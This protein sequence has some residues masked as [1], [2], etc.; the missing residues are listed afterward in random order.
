MK[1]YECPHCHHLQYELNT[2]NKCLLLMDDKG[3]ELFQNRQ[4][5]LAMKLNDINE[6]R[7]ISYNLKSDKNNPIV[8]YAYAY[9]IM[10][11]DQSYIND[12][13]ETKYYNDEI[14]S[15]MIGHI[16]DFPDNIIDQYLINVYGE[17]GMY[18]IKNNNIDIDIPDDL[19][20]EVKF[21]EKENKNDY[22]KSGIVYIIIG[23]VLFA[24]AML[25]IIGLNEE[26]KY[27]GTILYS[28]IPSLFAGVGVSK[29]IFK[30]KNKI[31]QTLCGLIIFIIVTYVLLLPESSNILIHLKRILLSPVEAMDYYLSRVFE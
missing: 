28:L 6:I 18:E 13:I 22:L 11:E 7:K 20:I 26:K 9:A 25:I 24:I 16:K 14:I 4:L 3:N 15:H 17:S 10:D 1:K 12:F 2:C 30:K 8:T 23:I 19:K 31:L 5:R 27:F 21:I 29:L